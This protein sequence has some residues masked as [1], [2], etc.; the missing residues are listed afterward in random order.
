MSQYGYG[1][2]DGS[3]GGNLRL[4]LGI[5]IALFAVITYFM[6]STVNPTTGEAQHVSMTPSQEIALGEASAPE[7]AQQM[8]GE[9]PADSPE[10]RFVQEVGQ[11]IASTPEVSRSP[12]R[13]QYHLLADTRT[14]NAFALP[15]GQVFVTKGLLDKLQYENELAGVLGHETGHVVE[16]HSAQQLEKQ[17]LGRELVTAAGVGS[18]RGMRAAMVASVADQ[19]IQ[20]HFSREDESQ[21]DQKGLE[22][23]TAAGYD[24]RGMEDVMKV[25]QQLAGRGAQPEFLSDHPDPGNRIQA[26]DQWLRDHPVEQQRLTQGRP[27]P[28][29]GGGRSEW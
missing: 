19:M 3:G 29:E 16:R 1:Y 7:M 2:G 15:G 24:P 21:A 14:V 10:A 28:H 22:Y 8:G 11:K 25:L 20:L 9:A 17:N 4:L 13:Y 5:G 12:Y 23:M 26:I 6:H 18:R 27:V